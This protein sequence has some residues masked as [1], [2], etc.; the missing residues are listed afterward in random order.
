MEVCT[1]KVVTLS[2]ETLGDEKR[3][4]RV[5][6]AEDGPLDLARYL[7]REYGRGNKLL[8]SDVVSGERIM[9]VFINTLHN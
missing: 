6:T 4:A 3:A 7:D 9:L 5:V 2:L 1:H 8:S